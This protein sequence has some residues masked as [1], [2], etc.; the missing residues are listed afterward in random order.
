MSNSF[1]DRPR[2]VESCVLLVRESICREQYENTVSLKVD[3]EGINFNQERQ[4]EAEKP[5]YDNIKR[6]VKAKYGLEVTSLYI[7]QV[8]G[9]LGIKGRKNYN[10]GEGKGV[11]PHCP[12]KKEEAIKNALRHFG[13][14][15]LN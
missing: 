1:L 12:P 13:M 6:W 4:Q 10:I 8:K 5:T 2:H 9:K 3:L 15:G 11:V 7:A 14:I